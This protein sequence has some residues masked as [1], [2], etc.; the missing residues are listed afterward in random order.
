M[1]REWLILMTV[2]AG[3]LVALVMVIPVNAQ[4]NTTSSS[5]EITPP[6][7]N[8]KTMECYGGTTLSDTIETPAVHC[9]KTGSQ[10]YDDRADCP[11]GYVM[12][13]MHSWGSWNSDQEPCS[14]ICSNG[15][16]PQSRCG[17]R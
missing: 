3:I 11:T 14:S 13:G 15:Q 10:S 16:L 8:P 9:G 1:L 7:V 6:T 12:V 5:Q 2:F 17:W 4:N